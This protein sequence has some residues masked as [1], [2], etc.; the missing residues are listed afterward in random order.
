MNRRNAVKNVLALGALSVAGFSGYKYYSRFKEA[1]IKE[2][3][4]YKNLIAELAETIIPQ[5]DT[6]GAKQANVQDFIINIIINCSSV[7]EQ[8]TFLDGLDDVQEYCKSNYRKEFT[9]C[10][11]MQKINVMRYFE[12]KSLYKIGILNKI[13]QKLLGQPFFVRLKALTVIGYCNSFYGA[14]EGLAYDYIPGAY[15]ACEA[16]QPN[17]KSWA[18]K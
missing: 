5:T 8:N 7:P 11:S 18:T 10:S 17:Q 4:S 15:Q 2:I 6:P 12:E 13:N 9:H 14:T 16:I 1:N 3:Y